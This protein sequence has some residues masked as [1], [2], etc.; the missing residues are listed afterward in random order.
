MHMRH[1][2]GH[3]LGGRE[4][5]RRGAVAQHMSTAGVGARASDGLPRLMVRHG[6]AWGHM[7]CACLERHGGICAVPAWKGT[8]GMCCACMERHGGMC[9]ACMESHGG[10]CAVPA[11]KGTGAC[12]VPAWKVTGAFVLCLHGKARGH[13]CC[14]CMERHGGMCCACMESHVGMCCA[15]ME[16]H[17]GM[18]CLHASCTHESTHIHPPRLQTNLAAASNRAP[19]GHPCQLHLTCRPADSVHARA[20]LIVPPGSELC[21]PRVLWAACHCQRLT[22]PSMDDG[23]SPGRCHAV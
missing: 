18:L 2:D 9:C 12:A 19:P 8:G 14:A 4:A 11:W 21:E 10:I 7:C 5:L 1:V 16:R 15:C 17:G 3:P 23:A 20:C 13:L 22:G 6:K